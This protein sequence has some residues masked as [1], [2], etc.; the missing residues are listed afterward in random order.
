MKNICRNCVHFEIIKRTGS[1]WC[2]WE[3]HFTHEK[4]FCASFKSKNRHGRRISVAQRK[5]I[6][7]LLSVEVDRIEL[8]QRILSEKPSVMFNPK[9]TDGLQ[10]LINWQKGLIEQMQLSRKRYEYAFE[11]KSYTSAHI[12]YI[13]TERL[14]CKVKILQGFI[15]LI[16]TQK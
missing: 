11:R 12:S 16:K 8:K 15:D 9:V 6:K 10:V 13:E 7:R 5:E 14:L 3:D 4:F 2:D 1:K